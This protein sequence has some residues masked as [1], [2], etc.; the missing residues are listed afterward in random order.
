MAIDLRHIITATF[1]LTLLLPTESFAKEITLKHYQG[2]PR[3]KYGLTLLQ[4]VLER[5]GHTVRFEAMTDLNEARGEMLLKQDAIDFEFL[6]TSE[7]REQQLHAIKIPIYFGLLGARLLLVRNQD[8]GKFKNFRK[9][10]DL[11][12][13]TAGHGRHW[14]DLGVFEANGLPVLPSVKYN[15]IFEQL[16]HNRTDY[17]AEV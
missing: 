14:S 16:V 10:S 7:K 4:K 13:L 2:H 3:Y 6:S 17:F 15:L 11:S 9:P 12:K 8:V 5:N 1:L